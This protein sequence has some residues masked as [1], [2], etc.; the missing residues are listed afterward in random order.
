MNSNLG[1]AERNVVLLLMLTMLVTAVY[2]PIYYN[3]LKRLGKL[4]SYLF[5]RPRS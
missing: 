5:I 4:Y 1:K 2:A 3:A